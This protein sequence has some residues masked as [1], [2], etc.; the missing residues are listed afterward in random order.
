MIPMTS[1]R[2]EIRARLDRIRARLGYLDGDRWTREIDENGERIVTA[3][4]ITV[5]RAA[6]PP[7]A[8]GAP[9]GRANAP[10]ARSGAGPAGEGG[11]HIAG[12]EAPETL[13]TFDA[14]AT[15]D[16]RMMIFDIREDVGF[17]LA[18]ID[19]AFAALRVK[20]REDRTKDF[21]AEAAMKCGSAQFQRFLGASSATVADIRLKERLGIDSKRDLNTDREAAVRWRALR[22]E[23]ETWMR[24]QGDEVRT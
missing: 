19:R 15:R 10:G 3:R 24:G 13:L 23:F 8:A 21:A 17:L 14:G 11:Q 20:R 12:H 9:T 22:A 6:P 2:R 7:D 4:A 1:D 5:S 18:T 16:E